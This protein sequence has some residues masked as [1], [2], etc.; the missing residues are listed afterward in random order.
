V[1]VRCGPD[2]CAE[3]GTTLIETL[4]ACSILIVVV[5]GLLSMTILATNLTEN[6]GHLAPRATAYAQDKME[7]LLSL[8]YGDTQTDTTV[9]P[10][11]SSGGAGLAVGGSD[12]PASPVPQYV[13]YIDQN[14]NLL[15]SSG[16]TAP[17]GW[18]CERAWRVSSPPGS[19]NLKEIT[20]TALIRSSVAGAQLSRSTMTALKTFP[21]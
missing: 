16:S 1:R 12:D 20:V 5:T 21:F 19:V 8:K 9:S 14:G 11:A 2:V 18:F 17:A 10:V 13:D 3:S 15:A 4:I 6:Q 7:Q